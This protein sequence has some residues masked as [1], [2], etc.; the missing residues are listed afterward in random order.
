MLGLN[1]KEQKSVSQ[2]DARGKDN[3]K[4]TEPAEV[5]RRERIGFGMRAVTVEYG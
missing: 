5:R 4:G 3:E 2:A 1:L